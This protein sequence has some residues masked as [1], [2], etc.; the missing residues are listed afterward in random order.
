MIARAVARPAAVHL[1]VEYRSRMDGDT[2]VGYAAVY[3]QQAPVRGGWEQIARG[4]FDEALRRGDPVVALVDHNPSLVLGRTTAG[5]LRLRSDTRGLHYEI[6]LPDTTYARDL[7][8]LV[9][10][11]DVLG[12]SFGF[13]PGRDEL[14][15]HSDGRLLRTHTSVAKLIDVSVVTMPAYSGTSV[16]LGKPAP[17]LVGA[18]RSKPTDARTQMIRIRH[19]QHLEDRARGRR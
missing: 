9:A 18:A 15:R 19:K 17:Q 4:A 14:G 3:G 10:R 13:I 2:L 5:T 12:A 8:E 6:D 11:G 7:K 16:G 1:A